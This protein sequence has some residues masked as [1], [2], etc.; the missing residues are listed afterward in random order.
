M[1]ETKF[2]GVQHEARRF[3]DLALKLPHVHQVPHDGMSRFGQVNADLMRASCFESTS[4]ERR[5]DKSF[6]G[7]DV[8]DGDLSFHCTFVWTK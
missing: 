2:F 5:T 8:R 3:D 1:N 6:D 7:F 4:D